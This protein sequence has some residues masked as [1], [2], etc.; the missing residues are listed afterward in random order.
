MHEKTGRKGYITS[1]FLWLQTQILII[2]ELKAYPL[3]SARLP[4][5]FRLTDCV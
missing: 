3:I 2:L 1:I 5:H 4:E